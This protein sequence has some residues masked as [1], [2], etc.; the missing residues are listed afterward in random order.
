MLALPEVTPHTVDARPTLI[1][2][3]TFCAGHKLEAYY[4][5]LT[6]LLE[7]GWTLDML[8]VVSV[9]REP[10][11][12][13]ASW[14]T[15]YGHNNSHGHPVRDR[16]APASSFHAAMAAVSNW[17]PTPWLASPACRWCR[18]TTLRSPVAPSRLA[19]AHPQRQRGAGDVLVHAAGP[20]DEL[21]VEPT[22]ARQRA[23]H[24][25]PCGART[26][27]LQ[28]SGIEYYQR[29]RDGRSGRGR[30]TAPRWHVTPHSCMDML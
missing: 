3:E 29:T 5:P 13:F 4:D 25:L 23:Q 12:P 16:K 17:T 9:A 6:V 27:L 8:T 19:T 15:Q 20:A 1:M 7:A 28:S 2:K 22:A 14:V 30:S 21:S 26:L 10:L 18:G 24:R 11:A